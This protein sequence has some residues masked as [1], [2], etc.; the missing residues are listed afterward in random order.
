M[1]EI[2]QKIRSIIHMSKPILEMIKEEG[3]DKWGIKYVKA[4]KSLILIDE[5]GE[6]LSKK[7]PNSSKKFK[8]T[9]IKFEG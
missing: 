6:I 9:K 8:Q 5:V 7:D 4:V 2:E 3:E 1:N